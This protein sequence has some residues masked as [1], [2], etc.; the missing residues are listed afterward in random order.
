MLSPLVAVLPPP[1]PPLDATLPRLSTRD[2]NDDA[3]MLFLMSQDAAPTVA[4]AAPRLKRRAEGFAPLPP[5]AAAAAAASAAMAL[6]GL[7]STPTPTHALRK[8]PTWSGKPS[9]AASSDTQS[10]SRSRRSTG[11]R[12]RPG[13]GVASDTCARTRARRSE[14]SLRVFGQFHSEPCN[15]IVRF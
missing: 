6:G 3:T 12:F 8:T 9:L 14:K 10:P 11:A 7:P 4:A 5:P 1:P 13:N 15:G 2:A